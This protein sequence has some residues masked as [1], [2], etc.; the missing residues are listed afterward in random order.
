MAYCY[1]QS[2]SRC[3]PATGVN[4]A[5]SPRNFQKHFESAKN[6][7]LFGKT[8]SYNHWL[9]QKISAGL[10]A[11][12]SRCIICQ[13][14]LCSTVTWGK[15]PTTVL[16]FGDPMPCYCY[17]IKTNSRTIRLQVPPT[18][19]ANCLCRQ[20]NGHEWTATPSLHD[21][22]TVNLALVQCECHTGK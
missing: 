12:L 4:W 6:F 16:T 14:C 10:V 5:I 11:T 21:T 15:A 8:T 22:R 9:P 2:L 20:I 18:P 17:A 1:Q 19:V 7:E 3:R 13:W